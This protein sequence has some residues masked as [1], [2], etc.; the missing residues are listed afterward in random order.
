M[1]TRV[2]LAEDHV[3][4]REGF[5]A[6]IEKQTDIE[7]VGEASNG[8]EVVELALELEP[9]VVLMDV[10]M[11]GM[12]GIEATRRIVAEMKNTKVLALSVHDDCEFVM[13]MVK[14]G[15]SGYLLKDCVFED[16]V[17]AIRVVV[18]GE[19]YLSPKIASIVLEDKTSKCVMS[20]RASIQLG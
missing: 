20:G 18:A 8:Q 7:V 5:R 15:V 10:G 1:R 11:P 6:L 4:V 19:S 14:A 9:D 16:L 2:L 17:K 13:G 12:N 3:V